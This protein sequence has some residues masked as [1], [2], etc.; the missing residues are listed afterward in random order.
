MA[1]LRAA[2]LAALLSCLCSLAAL[3]QEVTLTSLDNELT[4]SGDLLGF[5][6]EFYR[7]DTIYG[8]LTVDGS[9]VLCEGL[10]CPDLTSYVAEITL[11]GAASIGQIL[12]PALIEAFALREG[13]E[14][15]RDNG[16]AN[17]LSYTLIDPATQQQRGRFHLKLS[18]TDE[19]FADQLA[20]ETDIVM[21]QREV[22]PEEAVRAH[23]AGLGDLTDPRRSRLLA[24]DALVPMV[25]AKNPV[26]RITMDELARILTG[27]IIDWEQ[28]GG[29]G[30]AIALHLLD[31]TTSLGQLTPQRPLGSNVQG[32]ARG[33][34]R[35]MDSAALSQAVAD[36][37]LS[38]GIASRSEMG[39]AFE[40]SLIGACGFTMRASQRAIK[41]EDYPLTAPMFLYLPAHRLPKLARDFLAF[42]REPAAHLVVRRAGFVDQ[43]PEEITINDQGER[44]A[45]AILRAGKEVT[46]SD[47][48]RMVRFLRPLKRL[49]T[50]FRFEPDTSRPDAQSRSNVQA[51]AR[52]LENGSF[53]GRQLV[54]VGFSDSEGSARTNRSIARQRARSVRD[55]V[56]GAAEN[57]A[58]LDHIKIDIKAFGEALPM[59]CDD[60]EWGRHANRRVEIWVR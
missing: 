16:P 48:Q 24:L 27:E 51:L 35:H 1:T 58:Q 29:A 40:L 18:N 53:D 49:T 43:L 36:D 41:T 17:A 28:L 12:M 56:I 11:S 54:F 42:T 3:A 22:R 30:G 39:E 4:I 31:P 45:N 44:F 32:F 19:G 60:S 21:S 10:G 46:L 50:T 37:P 2:F 55:A 23:D 9:G 59:A 5:D 25:S 14:A 7:V 20:G 38:L 33:V 57:A 6:G 47:L 26:T 13:L 8:E 52:A 34:I 15:T